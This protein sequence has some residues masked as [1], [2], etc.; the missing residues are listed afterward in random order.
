MSYIGECH[1]TVREFACRNT[2]SKNCTSISLNC[3]MSFVHIYMIINIFSLQQVKAFPG[4]LVMLWKVKT[5]LM[6]FCIGTAYQADKYSHFYIKI[7]CLFTQIDTS[8]SRLCVCILRYILLYQG[9]VSVYSATFISRLCVFVHRY[10]LL[11]QGCVSLYSDRYFYV[12][13]VLC[14]FVLW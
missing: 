4:E 12:K 2:W 3:V 13:V 8:I 11:C 9:C 14:V 7:V 10:I 1:W 6:A 5:V